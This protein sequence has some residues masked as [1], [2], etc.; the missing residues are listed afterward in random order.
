VEIKLACNIHINYGETTDYFSIIP[1]SAIVGHFQGASV[2]H[3]ES[4]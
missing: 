1:A 3:K 2:N 4:V